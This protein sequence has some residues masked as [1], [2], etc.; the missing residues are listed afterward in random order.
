MRGTGGT[1][2]TVV[3]VNDHSDYSALLEL[4]EIEI[5]D[6]GNDQPRFEDRRSN[7]CREGCGDSGPI[8]HVSRRSEV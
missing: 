1:Y 3:L 8:G 6:G 7:E 4:V 2:D 5:R